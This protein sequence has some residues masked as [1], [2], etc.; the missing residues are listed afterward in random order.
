MPCKLRNLQ[1]DSL[2][3]PAKV[4]QVDR[5]ATNS[6]LTEDQSLD[7]TKKYFLS[8]KYR[9]QVG[10]KGSAGR[11]DKQLGHSCGNFDFTTNTG[12]SPLKLE[13]LCEFSEFLSFFPG[14]FC[15]LLNLACFSFTCSSP[16]VDSFVFL[17]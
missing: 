11:T 14:F 5:Q 3:S 6:W 2:E 8:W 15:G 17:R 1:V 12:F 16:T 13:R 4:L 7:P 10:A 9:K